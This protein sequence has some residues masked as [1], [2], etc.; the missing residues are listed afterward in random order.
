VYKS[1]IDGPAMVKKSFEVYQYLKNSEFDLIQFPEWEG[2]GY[3]T[4]LAKKEG[5]AFVST[6]IAV[7]LHGP[8]HWVVAANTGRTS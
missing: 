2:L 4:L 8:T 7:G 1:T 6:T 5:L 3:Y